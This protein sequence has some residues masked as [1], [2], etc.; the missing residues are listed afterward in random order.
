MRRA[1]LDPDALTGVS[2]QTY[3]ARARDGTIA[4]ELAR[5]SVTAAWAYIYRPLRDAFPAEHYH[6]GRTL[7]HVETSGETVT[8][9]FT[10]G[11]REHGALLIGADGVQSAVR[12][13]FA[14]D[15]QPRYAGYV[16]WRGVVEEPDIPPADCEQIFEHLNFCFAPSGFLLCIPI[17]EDRADARGLRHRRC[18]YIWYRPA[19]REELADLCTDATGKP[20][21]LTIPPPLIRP[22]LVRDV[23]E[24]GT[25]EFAPMIANIVTRTPQHLLQAMTDLETPRMAFGRVA[26]LGDAAFVA[27][28]HAVAGVTKAALD[29]NAL[30]DALAQHGTDIDAALAQYDASQ[31]AFGSRLVEHARYLGASL[32]AGSRVPMLPPDVMLRDYGAPHILRRSP[33]SAAAE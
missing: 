26:L 27:R 22:E 16:A 19:T 12:Q 1:G 14:P 11:T 24:T 33:E 4:F 17:P 3:I 2:V 6:A 15:A 7:A 18:C 20:H 13:Q 21:G 30:A 9:H 8:A 23:I 10:D 28:P 31:R 32:E 5:K 25:R 29:A